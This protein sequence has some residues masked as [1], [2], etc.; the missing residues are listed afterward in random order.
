MTEEG[1]ARME[2]GEW[3]LNGVHWKEVVHR[4][5]DGKVVV[6]GTGV[7]AQA[8]LEAAFYS[9]RGSLAVSERKLMIQS[10]TRRR[11]NTP[12]FSALKKIRVHIVLCDSILR[13]TT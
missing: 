4:W 12:F 10:S 5:K 7:D 11:K 8:P 6:D 2:G 13:I 1:W 9:K 3:G